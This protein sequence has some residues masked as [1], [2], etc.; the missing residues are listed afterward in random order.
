MSHRML[1]VSPLTLSLLSSRAKLVSS[2]GCFVQ[3]SPFFTLAYFGIR[4]DILIGLSQRSN[5]PRAQL[6]LVHGS[7][8]DIKC[9]SCDYFQPNNFD[10]PFHPSLAIDSQN[11]PRLLP[12]ANT[13]K[14][15]A[16]Y[17]DPNVHTNT[18]EPSDLPHC[19]N[20]TA[21]LLRPGVVWFG[22]NLP[23]NTMQEIDA[24][25]D[26]GKVDIML[27]IGT[28]AK[29]YP[30]AGY[31]THAKARGARIVVVNM[32]GQEQ[33]GLGTAGYLRQKDFLFVGDAAKLLPEI[34]APIIGDVSGLI[35]TESGGA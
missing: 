31:V 19:P 12:S 3:Y 35:G 13:V 25:I 24:F 34:L 27:V 26:E 7:L 33:G 14:A 17:M 23:E 16:A 15:R 32:E 22:E 10:D 30:A 11:D 21:G 2:R 20:C 18:I 9:F 6:K 4:I 8:F 28:S 1:M 5:H 29:V